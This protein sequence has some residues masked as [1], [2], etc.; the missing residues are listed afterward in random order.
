MFNRSLVV[1][2]NVQPTIICE[3]VDEVINQLFKKVTNVLVTKVEDN[4]E[5]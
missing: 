4:L 5:A 1:E 2:V 3:L